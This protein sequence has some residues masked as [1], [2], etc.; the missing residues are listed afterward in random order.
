M[1]VDVGP[2][3]E[4]VVRV[5]LGHPDDVPGL[6]VGRL[7]QPED[8]ELALALLDELSSVADHSSSPSKTKYSRPRQVRPSLT[9][10]GDH[11]PKFWMR[12]TATSGA[13]M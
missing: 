1:I 6:D 5:R 12:P 8:L 4:V 9:M 2:V 7:D 13:W 3:G 11:E 10:N